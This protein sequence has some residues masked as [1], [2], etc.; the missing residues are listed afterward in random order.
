MLQLFVFG[1]IEELKEGL[2]L[3]FRVFL[4]FFFTP[5]FKGF[6]LI[7]LGSEEDVINGCARVSGPL[8]CS[9][10]TYFCLSLGLISFLGFGVNLKRLVKSA[11]A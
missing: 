2:L 4:V 8:G 3:L 1:S 6:L 10:T 7:R 9:E 11:S 5:P